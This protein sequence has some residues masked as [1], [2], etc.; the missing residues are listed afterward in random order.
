MGFKRR[1]E[2]Y[3]QIHERGRVEVRRGRALISRPSWMDHSPCAC[4]RLLGYFNYKYLYPWK[5]IQKDLYL[6]ECRSIELE[7][8]NTVITD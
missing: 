8:L 7:P 2:I 6:W 3:K 5:K 4:K 1:N